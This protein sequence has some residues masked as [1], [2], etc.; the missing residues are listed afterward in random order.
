MLCWSWARIHPHG[1]QI[2]AMWRTWRSKSATWDPLVAALRYQRRHKVGKIALENTWKHQPGFRLGPACHPFWSRVDLNLGRLDPSWAEVGQKLGRSWG[3]GRSW[4]QVEAMLRTCRA[5]MVNL[6]D[7]VPICK[8]FQ[9]VQ[10]TVPLL[11]GALLGSKMPPHPQLKLYQWTEDCWNRS[12]PLLSYHTLHIRCGRIFVGFKTGGRK[13]VG[14]SE[15]RVSPTPLVCH[16]HSHVIK[17]IEL[18]R[19]SFNGYFHFFGK[20]ISGVLNLDPFPFWQGAEEGGQTGHCHLEGEEQA[21]D[22]TGYLEKMSA[23]TW[24]DLSVLW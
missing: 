15:N 11:F 3:L 12:A 8:M 10:I 2:E 1:P 24:V 19:I 18:E 4:P 6:D 14:L 5:E 13:H 17:Q 22:E 20:L 16:Q 7:V 23:P 9:A 21:G